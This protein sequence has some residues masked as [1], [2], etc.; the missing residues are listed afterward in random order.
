MIHALQVQFRQNAKHYIR[1]NKAFAN[2]V[3]AG[4]RGCCLKHSYHLLL[5]EFNLKSDKCRDANST[6]VNQRKRRD[7]LSRDYQTSE[8]LSFKYN[9]ARNCG[10]SRATGEITLHATNYD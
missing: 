4:G 2:S 10:C 6:H 9:T 5:R 8:A 7:I 3:L 1:P